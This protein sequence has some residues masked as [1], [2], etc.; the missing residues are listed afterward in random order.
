MYNVKG[1]VPVLALNTSTSKIKRNCVRYTQCYPVIVSNH[2]KKSS[3]R[4]LSR[5]SRLFSSPLPDEGIVL[6]SSH[7]TSGNLSSCVQNWTHNQYS[8]E[9]WWRRRQL[10]RTAL[11]S[12]TNLVQVV[13]V[14]TLT[15]AWRTVSIT[16]AK[17]RR[18]YT[19]T[20]LCDERDSWYAQRDCS[21]PTSGN[22]DICVE[23]WIDNVGEDHW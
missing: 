6:T 19:S 3:S 4:I 12:D 14:V 13:Q 11:C 21:T 1:Y 10:I 17:M 9:P 18:I 7:Y 20:N 15:S 5:G 16:A 23:N 22:V 8:Y 2:S